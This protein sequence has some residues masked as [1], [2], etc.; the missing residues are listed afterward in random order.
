MIIAN[1]PY[2]RL[3]NQLELGAHLII[4]AELSGQRVCM[5]YFK[6]YALHFPYF[7]N[8][9]LNSYPRRRGLGRLLDKAVQRCVDLLIEKRFI[10]CVDYLAEDK[11]IFFDEMNMDLDPALSILKRSR[12]TALKAWRFRARKVAATYKPQIVKVYTPHSVI[13]EKGRSAIAQ[14]Q[15]DVVIG[16]HVRWG[17]YK[18]AFPENYFGLEVYKQRM[19]E[20][21]GLFPGKKVGFVVCS[22]EGYIPGLADLQCVFPRGDAVTDLYTLAQCDYILATHSTYSRWASYWA[23]KGIFFIESADKKINSLNDFKIF[24][25]DFHDVG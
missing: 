13:L 23:D 7:E 2:G 21:L 16:V 12:I 9:F 4:F 1:Y 11:W 10:P 25:F 17:D 19:S 6:D 15:C 24:D 8:N 20:T 3:G 14:L 18:T 5:T 22:E